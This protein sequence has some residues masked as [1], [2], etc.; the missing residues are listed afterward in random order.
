MEK[1]RE[2]P[3]PLKSAAAESYRLGLE[4]YKV[5]H[6]NVAFTHFSAAVDLNPNLADAFYHIGLIYTEMDNFELCERFYNMALA[7]DPNHFGA[8]RKLGLEKDA[9]ASAPIKI[10]DTDFYYH[11]KKEGTPEAAKIL[12]SLEKMDFNLDL[13]PRSQTLEHVLR[14]IAATLKLLVPAALAG[15]FVGMG[16]SAMGFGSFLPMALITGSIIF[17]VEIIE[18]FR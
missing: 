6:L 4:A 3:N 18:K 13:K 5:G 15:F 16:L 8:K 7:A 14:F 10:T 2:I 11:L 1:K 9:S 12:E 17:L